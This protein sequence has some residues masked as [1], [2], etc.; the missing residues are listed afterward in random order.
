MTQ[1]SSGYKPNNFTIQKNIPVKWI[2]N[3][4]DSNSCSGSIS[5][6][7][8]NV[9]KFLKPGENIIEFTPTDAGTIKFSCSMGMYTGKF[10][11]TENIN[12]APVIDNPNASSDNKNE[13][14]VL[15][16]ADA[17]VIKTRY[18]EADI[19]DISDI[20]PNEFTVKVGKPVRFEIYP[21]L[22]G[23]GCMS[24]VALPGLSTDYFFLEKGKTVVFNFT[25]EKT[26]SY[27]ITCAMGSIRGKIIVN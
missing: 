22:D 13:S 4:T 19:N 1:S 25:P 18:F 5:A 9:S 20:I 21:E 26:G 17:Q 7:K 27:N 6:P 3:S 15:S 16:P 10:T 2:I 23:V 14:A 12:T 11:V 8:I 24:S